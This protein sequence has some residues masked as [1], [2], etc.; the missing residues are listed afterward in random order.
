MEV[1]VFWYDEDQTIIVQEFPMVWTWD[2]F[3]DGVKKTVEMEKS[4]SHQVYVL[5]TQPPNGKTPKGAIL[6]H[7][8]TAIK[9]HPRNMRF[10]I[11]ATDNYFT[12]LF[13]NIFLKTTAL[14]KKARMVNKFEDALRFIEADKE[15]LALGQP[16]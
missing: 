16:E 1:K 15:K 8:E 3:Y 5:G 13:G 11:I 9:M 10:Y 6:T 2:E 7:Y 4:V 12:S 14:R